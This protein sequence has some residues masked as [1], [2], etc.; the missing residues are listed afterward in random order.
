MAKVLQYGGQQVSTEVART[1]TL[2]TPT[3]TDNSGVIGGAMKGLLGAAQKEVTKIDETDAENALV[4]FEREKNELF[5]N[6]ETGYFSTSGKNAFDGRESTSKALDD[7]QK[8][9]SES[10]TNQGARDIFSRSSNVHVTRGR[11]TIAKHASDGFKAYESATVAARVENSIETGMLYYN[12]NDELALQRQ[13]GRQAVI[14]KADRDGLDGVA[15]NELLQNYDSKF[16][17]AIITAA[18]QQD[19]SRA[20]ELYGR[21]GDRLEGSEALTIAENMKKLNFDADALS[22]SSEIISDGSRS[23]A[24]MVNDVNAMEINT[25]EDAKIKTEVMRQVKN[26]Y[27]LN[28]AIKDEADVAAFEDYAT[29]I[30][31]GA[32]QFGQA[33]FTTKDIP[34]RVWE[35]MPQKDRNALLKMEKVISSG[36]NI[37]TDEV[38]LNDLMMLPKQELAKLRAPMYFD[39]V[40]G[41]DRTTLRNAIIAARKP[42]TDD[43]IGFARTRASI[44]SQSME[45]IFGRK[46]SKYSSN[47]LKQANELHRMINAESQYRQQMLGRKLT[48]VEFEDLMHGF[49]R[50]AVMGKGV[51]WDSESDITDV[52]EEHYGVISKE[53]RARGVP[54]TS[55]NIIKFYGQA[56][57]QGTLD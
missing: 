23:L 52:P 2:G 26:Q 25:P 1:P 11:T 51:F 6:A 21:L 12:N 33:S 53:L 41:S 47:Q 4:Q 22:A 32:G 17:A 31:D 35:N 3:I 57:A 34:G 28:K 27:S 24:D 54:V 44:I 8:K 18:G 55:D 38:L 39:R 43:T 37:A 16:A 50:K 48:P 49:T 9:Y 10:L 7:L 30:E 14:D 29:Q 42:T 45:Q 36:D 40:G 13:V 46:S 19:I 5:F 20:N 56:K 15:K